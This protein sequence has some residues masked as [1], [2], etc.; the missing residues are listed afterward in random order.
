MDKD[1]NF[2]NNRRNVCQQRG[3]SKVAQN[4]RGHE[5]KE[6]LCIFPKTALPI[7][8]RKRRARTLAERYAKLQT[9]NCLT[10]R[11]KQGQ[12]VESVAA[13]LFKPLPSSSIENP[14]REQALE[15]NSK[16]SAWLTRHE[17]RLRL[18]AS[19]FFSVPQ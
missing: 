18:E 6:K 12:A 1:L 13:T 5:Q 16:Y 9:I 2:N 14:C 8:E 3:S 11:R 15:C 10:L 19:I 7:Q 17:R 4:A